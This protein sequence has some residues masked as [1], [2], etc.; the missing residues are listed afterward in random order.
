MI[1]KQLFW[2]EE[3]AMDQGPVIYQSGWQINWKNKMISFP[4]VCV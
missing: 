4:D 3:D 1:N 2:L